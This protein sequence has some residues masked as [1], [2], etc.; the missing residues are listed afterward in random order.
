V[1]IVGAGLMGAQMPPA[2]TRRSHA[3]C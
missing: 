3:N 2:A 1:A